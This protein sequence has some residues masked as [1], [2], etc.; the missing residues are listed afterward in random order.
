MIRRYWARHTLFAD[1]LIALACVFFSLGAA[2]LGA[3]RAGAATGPTWAFSLV[4]LVL[5]LAACTAVLFRRRLPLLPFIL[6]TALQA[7]SVAVPHGAAVAPLVVSTYAL[8]VYG[9]NRLCALAA[10]ATTVLVSLLS[11]GV[12]GATHPEIA[13][14]ATANTFFNTAL[15]VVLGALVGVN[16]GNRKRYLAAVIE[17]SRRLLVERDQ[18]AELAAAAERERIAREMH[19]IVS[20][21]LTVIVALSEGANATNDPARA[22][23]AMAAAT[24]TARTALA[25]MRA[26]LGILRSEDPAAP[27]VPEVT[28]G[29]LVA[30]AQRAGFPVTLT[31]TGAPVREPAARYAVGRIVQEGLTNAMR[32]APGAHSISVRIDAGLERVRVQVDNDGATGAADTGGFGIRGLHERARHLGGTVESGPHGRD[33]W[34]L[35]ADLPLSEHDEEKP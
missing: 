26:M 31:T 22:R 20:H 7:T 23:E 32:H 9:S 10:T 2:G 30:A 33:G 4:I 28:P 14:S 25:D 3:S 6:A 34:R 13:L 1:I 5:A 18:Q 15:C 11:I 24:T 29:A 8:A 16:V 17:R 27:L 21:S 12:L 35:R 19:D